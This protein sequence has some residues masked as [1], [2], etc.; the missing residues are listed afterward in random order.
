LD[1][2]KD[3]EDRRQDVPAQGYEFSSN[4]ESSEEIDRIAD[5]GIESM[6]NQ[7]LGLGAHSE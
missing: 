3:Y 2:V 7:L 5:L 6:S 1:K 4:R